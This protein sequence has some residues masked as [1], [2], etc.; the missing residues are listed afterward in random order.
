M[1]KLIRAEL[2]KIRT[3]NTWWIFLIAF[4]VCTA[5][6][7]T[8]WVLVADSAIDA[9]KS[10]SHEVF[11]PPPPDSGM[12]P[13][14][15]EESR[16]QFELERDINRT[17]VSNAANIYTSGQFFGLMFAMLLGTLLITNEY[18]HQT[19]TATFLTIPA[20]TKVI[21]SKLGTAML[22]AAFF[23][24]FATALNVAVGAIF[25]SAKGYGPQLAE[26]PVA[27]AVLLNGLAFALWGV[28]GVGIGVLIRSQ[29][30]AVVTGTVAYVVGT[31]LISGI[32][33]AL[34]FG[35][36]WK[37]VLYVMVAW[38]GVASSVMVSPERPFADSPDWWVGALVL[39]AYGILFGV[40]GTLITRRRDIS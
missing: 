39:V 15:I 25:F 10:L 18:Y 14:E 22:A 30:G 13:A 37:W 7:L 4:F 38:P 26:W 33:P 36:N 12:S 3:T 1:S 19:A 23:W 34:Y 11:T 16:R 27:R 40:V 28:L 2:L 9:A 24:L 32:F 31:F 29:I 20:R 8:I 6:V 21:L 5:G 17:L 35:L